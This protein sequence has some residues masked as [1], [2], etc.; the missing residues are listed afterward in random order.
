MMLNFDTRGGRKDRERE[1]EKEGKEKGKNR[2]QSRE[3]RCL[4]IA[5]KRE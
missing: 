5:G 4:G 2:F 1:G 3:F